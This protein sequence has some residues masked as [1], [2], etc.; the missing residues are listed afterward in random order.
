MQR[1]FKAIID[2]GRGVEL[3]KLVGEKQG[4]MKSDE[5]GR[6]KSMMNRC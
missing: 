5:V 6:L 3:Q 2:Y 1:E 4:G